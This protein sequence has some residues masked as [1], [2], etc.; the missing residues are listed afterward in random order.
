VEVMVKLE[1][2]PRRGC[3]NDDQIPNGIEDIISEERSAV[4]VRP[5]CVAVVPTSIPRPAI[6]VCQKSVER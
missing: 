1:L 4:R 6:S 3:F 2:W 5:V